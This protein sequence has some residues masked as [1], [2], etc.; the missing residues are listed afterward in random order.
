MTHYGGCAFLFNKDT[1]YLNID[2][3]SLC[4]NDFGRYLPDQLMEGDQ[5]VMQGVLSRASFRRPPL[6]GQKTFTV[7]FP[8]ISNMYAKSIAKKPILTIRA[9]MIGQHVEQ[10]AGDF[11]GTA[12]RCCNRNNISTIDEAFADCALPSPLGPTPLWGP[13]SIPNNWADVCGFLEPPDSDGYWKVRI[14]GAFST[15]HKTPGLRPTDQSCHH[16][17]WFHLEFVDWRSTQSHH[18]EHDRRILLKERSMACPYGS[19][20]SVSEKS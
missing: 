3:E 1:F 12:W 15:P 14:H 2:V 5:G 16:E 19:K 6:S 18:E 11:N 7:L 4:L 10:V 17:T 8:H 20:K 9:I 13:G